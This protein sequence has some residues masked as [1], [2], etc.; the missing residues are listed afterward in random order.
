MRPH[1]W[2]VDVNVRRESA[3]HFCGDHSFCPGSL[4]TYDG[5]DSIVRNS[6]VIRIILY[7]SCKLLPTLAGMWASKPRRRLCGLKLN[8]EAK[9]CWPRGGGGGDV[10]TNGSN[11]RQ[12]G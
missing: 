10:A 4:S 2:N 9:G 6:D 8:I 7:I 3:A 1:R 5:E 12:T 11:E